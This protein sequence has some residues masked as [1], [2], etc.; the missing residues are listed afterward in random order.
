MTDRVVVTGIGLVTP[1]GLN[2]ESTWNSLVEGRSGIDYIS[3]FDAEGYESRIAGE[4]DN[5]DASAALGRKEAKRLDRFSQFACVAALEAL[6]H[7]N[8]NMEKEDADRVGVLIGSGVGGIITIS[9]QHKILL[10]RG[11]K[12][13]SP[14]LVPMMLGDMASGQVSMMIGA[15]G[16]NFSTVSACATGADSIGEALEMIRR[17][18][19]DVVIAGGTEAAICEIGVAGF[20][21]CMALS[22]RN[23]DP[24][25]ASRPFD[26]DRDGFVLGEGAGLLV[27]E[28]LEHAEKRGAN[29][30]AEMSGY[31]AS[32]DAHHVTQPHPDGEG[33]ARA[34]KWAIE[35]A[36]I[37]PD[38]VDYINA[39]GT[40][41][42]L[43]DKYETIAMKRMYGD[44]AYNLAISSTKSMTGHLLGAAGAIEAAFTVLAIKNDIVPPTIN[45]ENPD[46]DCDLNYIP[47][48]AKK[49]P[50]NV[51]MSNSLGFGGHNASLVFERFAQ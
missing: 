47:N 14:F 50:V 33:A 38:K 30:L 29:I 12:R 42:P 9:D 16:P 43:N 28:S 6:E 19:A 48:T 31:G 2:S 22:T 23:E 20:N 34:M 37:T 1:V 46:P 44:H 18:R 17:G 13:V 49:Q 51:A 40:S 4:V 21:S 11:P 35:D 7:A 10:K 25:G 45:I 26:S 27:L 39:H 3:L 15:K 8:L 41:T 36:G 32:S 24:Q 5:F